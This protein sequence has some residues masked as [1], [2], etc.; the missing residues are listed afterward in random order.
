MP[1]RWYYQLKIEFARAAENRPFSNPVKE[2]STALAQL[3]NN[4]S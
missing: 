1:T 4:K 3:I 2:Q